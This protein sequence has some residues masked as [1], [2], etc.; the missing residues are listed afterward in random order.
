LDDLGRCVFQLLLPF[1]G[2][3]GRRRR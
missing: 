1:C 3:S 2:G